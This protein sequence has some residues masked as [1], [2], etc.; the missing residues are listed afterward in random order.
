MP[1]SDPY[2]PLNGRTTNNLRTRTTRERN[3][4]PATVGNRTANSTI[5]NIAPPP[6]KRKRTEG[7]RYMTQSSVCSMQRSEVSPRSKPLL[8]PEGATEKDP[9]EVE[10]SSDEING[11]EPPTHHTKK[12]DKLV[13][14]GGAVHAFDVDSDCPPS[15]AVESTLRIHGDGPSTLNLQQQ[16]E[17]SPSPPLVEG[18]SPI[19]QFD[20]EQKPSK[21]HVT[22]LKKIFEDRNKQQE[23]QSN[24]RKGRGKL[25]E[26][27]DKL[28]EVQDKPTPHIN[29]RVKG[30]MKPKVGKTCW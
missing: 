5:T 26:D 30:G 4:A 3:K 8:A 23:G 27:R 16:L 9:V 21:I 2:N 17:T 7:E 24:P 13:Q 18:S 19:E 22:K 25:H 14:N 12:R 15:N 6:R 1:K 29:L 28:D 10:S 20:D 11:F